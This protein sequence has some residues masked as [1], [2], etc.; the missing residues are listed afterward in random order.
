[1][2]WEKVDGSP[3]LLTVTMRGRKANDWR[4][5]NEHGL[6]EPCAVKSRTH[7]STG[8]KGP[9]GPYLS[10]L[11]HLTQAGVRKA[12]QVL[13]QWL[14]D[15]GLELKPSKTR[16]AHT[17]TPLQGRTGFDLPLYDGSAICCRSNP[18]SQKPT[19]NPTWLQDAH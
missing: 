18:L 2:A 8:G 7:G 17:L 4:E 14:R 3:W 13:E 15:I 12:W 6:S 9:R 16:V 19:G 11:F 10:Q 1:M 5:A